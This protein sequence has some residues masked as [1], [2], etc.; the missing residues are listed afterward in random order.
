[1]PHPSS[2]IRSIEVPIFSSRKLV[3]K[4]IDRNNAAV[5]GDDKI[6][7]RVSLG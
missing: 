4:K 6:G 5:T 7:S 3:E 1:M 2:G